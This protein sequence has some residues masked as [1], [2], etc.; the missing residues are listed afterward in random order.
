MALVVADRQD[1]AVWAAKLVKVEYEDIRKPI[2]TFHDALPHPERV[3]APINFV[4]KEKDK[5]YILGNPDGRL[6]V[7]ML[8]VYYSLIHVE[9]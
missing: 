8:T 5:P 7:L 3:D 1:T 6:N 9:R 2:L 4:T